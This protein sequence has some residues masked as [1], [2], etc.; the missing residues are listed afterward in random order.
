EHFHPMVSDW[1]NYESWDEG[2]RVEAHQRA[3]KL[4]RQLIDAHEEPPMDPARRAE[5]D[6]FVARRVAEGGVE[7]DY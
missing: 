2:G 1:R 6:D 4:A 7:T 5:L 3:E